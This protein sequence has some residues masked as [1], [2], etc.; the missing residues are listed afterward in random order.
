[1]SEIKDKLISVYEVKAGR[2]IFGNECNLKKYIHD[3]NKLYAFVRELSEKEKFMAKT[4]GAE[5]STM[6]KVNYNDKI[7]AGMYLE[8]RSETFVIQSV[9]GFC[10][11]KRDLTLRAMRCK[12]EVTDYEEYD[13]Q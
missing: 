1:M 4:S 12:P 3:R 13:E 9:D 6:F 7:N 11:Y 2:N 5:Q 8:F 10:W